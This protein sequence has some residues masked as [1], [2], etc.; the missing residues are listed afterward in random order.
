MIDILTMHN[1]AIKPLTDIT[2]KN[3]IEYC[4]KHSYNLCYDDFT[5]PIIHEN[6]ANKDEANLRK[7]CLIKNTLL[8]TESDWL[9]WIDGD[10]LIMNMQIPLSKFINDEFDFIIGEDWNGLNAGVFFIRNCMQSLEFINKCIEYKPTQFD[11]ENTPFWWWPSEQCA[12]TRLIGQV[13]DF[14]TFIV[15]HSYFNGYIIGPR[16]DNDWRNHGIGPFN[17]EWKERRFQSGD[18]I[19]HLVGDYLPNKIINAKKYIKEVIRENSTN[20]SR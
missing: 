15:H 4:D 7:L 17:K 2:L 12:Y 3:K 13:E 14:N 11:M 16:E 6:P 1:K 9:C 8:T 10:A 20:W 19:L 18:F 5:K